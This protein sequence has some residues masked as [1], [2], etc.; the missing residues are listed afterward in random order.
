MKLQVYLL[1]STVRNEFAIN[2]S[3]REKTSK[4]LFIPIVVRFTTIF[5]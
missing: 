4:Y 2:M 1:E 3:K 5:R